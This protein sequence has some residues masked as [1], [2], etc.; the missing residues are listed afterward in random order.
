MYASM[1]EGH[2]CKNCGWPVIY[3]L[4]KDEMATLAPYSSVARWVYCSNKACESHAGV[5]D[6][7][8]TI[9]SIVHVQ[10]RKPLIRRGEAFGL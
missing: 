2:I 8:G 4:C 6:I 3:A 1:C 9:P 5:I 10:D 7:P